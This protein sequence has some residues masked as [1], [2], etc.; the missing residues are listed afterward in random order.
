MIQSYKALNTTLSFKNYRLLKKKKNQSL[1]KKAAN[2][3]F[4]M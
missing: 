4:E 3:K 1:L 2:V